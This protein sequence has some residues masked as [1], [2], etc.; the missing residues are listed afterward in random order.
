MRFYEYINLFLILILFS[1]SDL[2]ETHYSSYEEIIKDNGFQRGWIPKFLPNSSYDIYEKHDIDNNK[3]W[4]SFKFNIEEL[5][6]L[7]ENFKI[8]DSSE[9]YKFKNIFF[10]EFELNNEKLTY[11]R[12][13]LKEYIALDK[14]NKICY[15]HRI[16]Y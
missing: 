10:R 9:I 7:I 13:S 8:P 4:V 3:V 5:N 1:C 15:Y 14:K 12:Y 2:M 6:V 11:F 16:K